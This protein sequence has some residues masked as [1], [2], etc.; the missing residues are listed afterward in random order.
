[1][2]HATIKYSVGIDHVDYLDLY[3]EIGR[4]DEAEEEEGDAAALLTFSTSGAHALD[5][6]PLWQILRTRVIT[7]M[8]RRPGLT[9]KV[10]LDDNMEETVFSWCTI[11]HGGLESC[12]IE[13]RSLLT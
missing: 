5:N 12:E 4:S 8:R 3:N 10:H 13:W 2:S 1:M 9:L 7:G 11:A 6:N